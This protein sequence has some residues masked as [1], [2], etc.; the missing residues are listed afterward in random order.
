MEAWVLFLDLSTVISILAKLPHLC[1]PHGVTLLGIIFQNILHFEKIYLPHASLVL[2][3]S[4][5]PSQFLTN[6]HR[7]T[8]QHAHN[9]TCTAPLKTGSPPYSNFV[10]S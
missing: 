10:R 3:F 4:C 5:S 2:S 1:Q 6:T 8:L 9:Q 7:C